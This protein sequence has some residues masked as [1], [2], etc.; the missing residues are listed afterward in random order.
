MFFLYAH[1]QP[2]Y[3]IRHIK[4]ISFFN[5]CAI[6]NKY[7]KCWEIAIFITPL[8]RKRPLRDLLEE[9]VTQN[10]GKQRKDRGVKWGNNEAT[11]AVIVLETFIGARR[12]AGRKNRVRRMTVSPVWAQRV[13]KLPPYPA[14][15]RRA[16]ILSQIQS[17]PPFA[18][19]L[20]ALDNFR[21]SS[22]KNL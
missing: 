12:S 18:Q 10:R 6:W 8:N 20:P 5:F 4:D 11:V 19:K 22:H 3:V 14:F 2:Q 7:T 16:Q 9:N 21:F 13:K 17:W 1:L 15:A